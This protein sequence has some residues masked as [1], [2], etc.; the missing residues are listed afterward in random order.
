VRRQSAAATALSCAVDH[1]RS[2]RCRAPLAAALQNLRA[3]F[4]VTYLL[5]FI[6]YPLLFLL[7]SSALAAP[8]APALSL[9]LHC[10]NPVIKAG[11]EIP[12]EFTVTNQGPGNYRYSDRT[13]D[14]SGRIGEYQ[15]T[16]KTESGEP[17]PDPRANNQGGM[18]GGVSAFAVLHPGESFS[19]IIP[20]NLWALVKAPGRYVVTGTYYGQSQSPTSA[21]LTLTVQPRT[22]AEMD[23]YIHNL[24]NQLAT[25]A[26]EELVRQLMYTGSPKMVPAVLPLVGTSGNV[27]FWAFHALADYAPH[28]PEVRQTLIAAAT[29]RGM[30]ANPSLAALLEI[31]GS[32]LDEVKALIERSL[33]SDHPQDWAAGA[34][35]AQHFCDDAFTPRLITIATTPG[36]D[37]RGNAIFALAQNRTDDG[38]QALKTLMNDPDPKILMPLTQ[39]VLNAGMGPGKPLRTNDF[40]ATDVQPL[41]SLLLASDTQ[42]PEKIWG[43]ELVRR[44]G[45]DG[46]GNKPSPSP[47]TPNKTS[48]TTP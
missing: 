41:I 23:A 34:Q 27:G 47:S 42:N 10:P 19:K 3:P 35:L 26:A 29:E 2:K 1:P 16:A 18:A 37:A 15:L 38:V 20:L 12:I 48:A 4:P 31:F 22:E 14:H 39:I 24:T 43:G 36:S 32:T 17:V 45:R 33:A 40:S 28:T 11:D 21:P 44:F 25:A 7:C 30:G 13:Y 46:A 9:T 5:S 8:A 6:L